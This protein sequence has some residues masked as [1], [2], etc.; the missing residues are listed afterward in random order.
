MA[1]FDEEDRQERLNAEAEHMIY[2][3][4]VREDETSA[5]F[6]DG[7]AEPDIDNTSLFE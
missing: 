2:D 1:M 7:G 6:G 5:M 4:K 3:E